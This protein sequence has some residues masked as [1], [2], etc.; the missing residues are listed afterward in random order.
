MHCYYGDILERCGPPLWWDEAAVPRY[1]PFAPDQSHDIYAREVALVEI[2]CQNCG[3][4]FRVAFSRSPIRDVETGK[5]GTLAAHIKQGWLHYGDPPN[6]RCC[7]AGR[8]MNCED[9][10]VL[11]YWHR[12][13]RSGSR[14][15]ARDERYEI[16]LPGAEEGDE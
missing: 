4:S 6:A 9:V 5:R 11:E 14:E 8:S 2:R 7:A 16:A 12:D 1:L 10:R 3:E 13:L 15:W